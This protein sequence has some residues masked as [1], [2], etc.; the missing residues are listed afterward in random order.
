MSIARTYI[1]EGSVL[2]PL[3]DDA[4][5][6]NGELSSEVIKFLPS[7]V[8]SYPLICPVGNSSRQ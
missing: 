8:K 7:S 5:E 4:W 2:N 6:I 1:G 3:K